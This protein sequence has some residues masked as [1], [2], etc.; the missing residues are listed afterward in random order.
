MMSQG[1]YV[2]ANVV[3]QEQRDNTRSA[4]GLLFNDGINNNNNNDFRLEV[5]SYDALTSGGVF[6][7]PPVGTPD[8]NN[9][10]VMATLLPIYG[11]TAPLCLGSQRILLEWRGDASV[12]LVTTMDTATTEEEDAS[13]ISITKV[14]IVL[15]NEDDRDILFHCLTKCLL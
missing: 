4:D 9:S 5:F 7:I 10:N 3:E 14:E 8:N 13:V 12:E 1:R 15:S 11:I 2:F 6:S